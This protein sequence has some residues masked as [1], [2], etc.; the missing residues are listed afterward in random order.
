MVKETQKYGDKSNKNVDFQTYSRKTVQALA[1]VTDAS[2]ERHV[3]RP[4]PL[5]DVTWPAM[6]TAMLSLRNS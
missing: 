5:H 4:K 6:P 1:S 3:L 2:Y